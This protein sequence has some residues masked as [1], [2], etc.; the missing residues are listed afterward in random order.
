MN[1]NPI[2]EQTLPEPLMPLGAAY[3]I[4]DA[5]GPEVTA[6]DNRVDSAHELL[7][8]PW[9]GLG[10]FDEP[11]PRGDFAAYP[12]LTQCKKWLG[13]MEAFERS[14]A[15]PVRLASEY[16]LATP[17]GASVDH[18]WPM[19]LPSTLFTYISPGLIAELEPPSSLGYYESLADLDLSVLPNV[20][21]RNLV[22]LQGAR[23]RLDAFELT[24][25][26]FFTSFAGLNVFRYFESSDDGC[27]LT[28]DE[29]LGI[30]AANGQEPRLLF[31]N[32]ILD[33]I[34]HCEKFERILK[35]LARYREEARDLRD[36]IS[37]KILS[38][39]RTLCC[40]A[41]RFCGLSWT[42]RFWFL[43]HGSH[44][45]RAEHWQLISQA[46]GCAEILAF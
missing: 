2:C 27:K 46:F 7:P 12:M 35:V 26:S 34:L 41:G 43:I 11:A 16:G 6:A 8:N 29:I 13:P 31:G 40:V 15:E 4:L 17:D 9:A 23:A 42:R 21:G 25:D 24:V 14:L 28:S 5:S 3:A 44:P 36:R 38:L 45:P 10:S 37:A 1:S 30:F 32:E 19:S 33:Y 39:K 18:Y 22:R 20:S